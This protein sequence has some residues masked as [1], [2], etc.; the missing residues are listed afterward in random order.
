MSL[1]ARWAALGEV[2]AWGGWTTGVAGEGRNKRVPR[3]KMGHVC[4]QRV[5]RQWV[6]SRWKAQHQ[7]S[8]GART[9][10]RDPRYSDALA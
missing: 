7:Q 10:G 9:R 1:G 6:D 4:T 8:L 3:M 2:S 5:R